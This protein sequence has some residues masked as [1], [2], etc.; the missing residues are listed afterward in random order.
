MELQ[1]LNN[2]YKLCFLFLLLTL[3]G[4]TDPKK[5]PIY[6]QQLRSS[7]SSERNKAAL[8]LGYIGSPKANSAVPYLIQLLE[9]DNPGVQSSAAFALR[10]IG[11]PEANAALDR[12]R[13]FQR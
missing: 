8:E 1:L 10:K 11:T 2:L 4:C 13:R 5:V 9:D 3:P 12:K 6:I 7:N